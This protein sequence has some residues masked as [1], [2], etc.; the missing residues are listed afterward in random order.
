[1]LLTVGE[2]VLGDLEPR[3]ARMA[4][5]FAG[6]VGDT[7]QEM[8]GALSGGILVI[9]GLLGRTS[10]DED[11]RP[12]LAL[13]TRYRRR[14]LAELG[15]TQCARLWEM[16]HAPGGLGSCALLVERAAMVLLELLAEAERGA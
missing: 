15:A 2:Y 9:G 12:A 5:G 4:T 13:A 7:Q 1:M 14:F 6:G 11:D 8:C 10:L 16:V 3:C